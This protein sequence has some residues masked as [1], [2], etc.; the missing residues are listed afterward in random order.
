MLRSPYSPPALLLVLLMAAGSIV[1]WIGVPLGL[2]YAAAQ[3]ADSSRPSAG[4]Y[5]LILVGLPIGMAIVA[6][7]LGWLD[8]LHSRLTGRER[9]RHRASWLRSMRAERTSTARGGVLD[10]VMIVSVAL[11][12]VVFAVWFFGF[13]GSSLPT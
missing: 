3:L 1:M 5:L 7:L 9:G 11:A 8:R 13:A 6:K 10:T 2:I 4:P 12:L